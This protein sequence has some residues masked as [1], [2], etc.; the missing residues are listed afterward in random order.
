MQVGEIDFLFGGLIRDLVHGRVDSAWEDGVDPDVLRPVFGGENLSQTDQSGF[1]RRIGCDTGKTDGVADKRA[2]EDDRALALLQHG[3]DLMLGGEER[4]RQIDLE[5]F[6]PAVKRNA[7]GRPLLAEGAGVVEGDIEAAVALL[8]S[9]C[10]TRSL[11]NTSSLTSPASAASLVGDFADKGI[12]FRV[13]ASRNDDLG[14]R[15]GKQLKADLSGVGGQRP[16][17]TGS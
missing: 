16:L 4:A 9:A 6:V 17:M 5:R 14:A 10:S 13:T 12:Q 3:R 7:R 2:R 1:A 8:R 15:P 11:A